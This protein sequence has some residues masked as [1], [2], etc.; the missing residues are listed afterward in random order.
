MA[1]P[2]VRSKQLPTLSLLRGSMTALGLSS[3]LAGC[4]GSGLEAQGNGEA[5]SEVRQAVLESNGDFE[6]NPFYTVPFYQLH[7]GSTELPGWN[8]HDGGID[9]VSASFWQAYRNNYSI[10]LNAQ[11]AGRISQTLQAP[12]GRLYRVRFA[13]AGNPYDGAK[14]KQLRVEASGQYQDYSF[15]V[16]GRSG[17]NMGWTEHTFEFAA[18]TSNPTLSF[19]SL[20]SD[21]GGPALD[22]ITVNEIPTSPQPLALIN[23]NFESGPSTTVPYYELAPGSTALPGWTIHEGGI[24]YI[25]SDF[26]VPSEGLRSIDLSAQSAGRIT[27]SL[28]TTPCRAYRVDFSLSGNP[29]DGASVKQL[30]VEA[31]GQSQDYSF[32]VSGLYGNFM[33]WQRHSFTFI[34]TTPTTTL[35]FR[36]LIND[37]GGPALDDISV[38]RL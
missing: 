14:V 34:A 26:W 30:R 25:R 16:T 11:S 35:S 7:P 9:L 17:T 20:I 18:C 23:G 22:T 28:T 12:G 2:C 37:N 32:N 21:N 5:L 3:L 15:D 38:T 27:Q 6:G 19:R 4:G 10:D 31:A 24:D 29:Y 36:S 13:L 8:I 1:V 33:G